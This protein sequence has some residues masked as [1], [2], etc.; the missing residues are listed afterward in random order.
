MMLKE[1]HVFK[2]GPP[3][4]GTFLW[5]HFLRSLKQ[6]NKV[7]ENETKSVFTKK[8]VVVIKWTLDMQKC[9]ICNV[10]KLTQTKHTPFWNG[11]LNNN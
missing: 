8:N 1:G 11:I 5:I 3:S 4:H 10:A 2:G 6:K 7:Y 9:G